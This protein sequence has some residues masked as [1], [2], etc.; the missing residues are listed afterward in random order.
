MVMEGKI[1]DAR[2]RTWNFRSN[3]R[4][5]RRRLKG[6]EGSG[7]RETGPEAFNKALNQK[8]GM[9]RAIAREIIITRHKT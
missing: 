5:E 1:P 9:S 6:L 3:I 4:Q 7:L 8:T 2:G